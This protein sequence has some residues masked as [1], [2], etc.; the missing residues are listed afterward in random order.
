M[1]SNSRQVAFLFPGQGSQEVGMGRELAARYP[2][3]AMVFEEADDLVG[4]ALSRL[5]WEGPA[6]ELNDT[7]NTQPALLCHSVAALRVLESVRPELRP[8]WL[9]GHS[10]G[11]FSAL[12]AARAMSF[13]DALRLVRTRGEA[14]KAAGV[15]SPGG[16][17]AVLGLELEA[18]EAACA[19]AQAATGEAVQVA[20]DNCPGQLVISGSKPA[21]AAA[22]E[23]L[24]A[25]GARRVVELAVSIAAHSALMEPAQSE[26]NRAI[27]STPISAPAIPV[28]GNVNAALLRSVA[29][30]REELRSQLTS[31]VRWTE[32]IQS[33]LRAGVTGFIELG[34][35]DV[36]S[37]L[38]RRIDREVNTAAVG[39]PAGI[40]R[41]SP[42]PS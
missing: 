27:E 14:M 40:D 34:T 17:A 30:I 15:R 22:I 38:V 20:N 33:M 25:N 37:N 6:E 10:L 29:G 4:F 18:V 5:C 32:T 41:L 9:A 26:L 39:D 21:L 23:R 16:M 13:P 8:N 19:A 1:G 12:V 7:I 3:A 28:I 42:E 36:L 2:A 31:R 11:E 24:R 35:R